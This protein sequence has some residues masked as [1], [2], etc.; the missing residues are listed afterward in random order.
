MSKSTELIES[1]IERALKAGIKAKFLLID[2]W[3]AMPSLISEACKHVSVSCMVKRT[4]KIHY[5]FEG[6]KMDVTQIYSQIRKRCG[7]ANILANAQVESRMASK[8]NSSSYATSTRETGWPCL[9]LTAPLPM[10][11]LSAFTE[12]AGIS[13]CSSVW[14]SSIWNWKRLPGPGLR[15]FHCSHDHRDDPIHLPEHRETQDGRSKNSRPAL[16]PLLRRGRRLHLG[17]SAVPNS[18]HHPGKPETTWRSSEP[19]RTHT[20]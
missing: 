2:S 14:P 12:H 3:F 6:Q 19:G 4:P 16:P 20:A 15:R 9:P 13:K 5:I 8:P 1:M 10:K 7:R 17:Q 18:R 11:T